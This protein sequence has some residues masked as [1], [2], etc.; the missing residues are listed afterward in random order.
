MHAT[1][2]VVLFALALSS[3][4]AEPFLRRPAIH[5]DSVAFTAEGDLWIASVSNGEARRLTT[6]EGTET[7]P[8]FSPDGAQ[9]AFT[10]EYDGGP[11]LYVVGQDPSNAVWWNK[12]L[13]SSSQWSRAGGAAAGS[14]A[15]GPR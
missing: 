11:D 7:S 14:L 10:G 3:N 5:G 13:S 2:A 6:H 15:A 1:L 4:A 8:L 9:I 12:V